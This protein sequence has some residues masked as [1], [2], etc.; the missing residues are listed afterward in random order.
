MPSRKSTK[1]SKKPVP[2]RPLYGVAI[3]DAMKRGD[4]KE[5]SALAKEGRKQVASV[6][7]ALATLEKKIG[8]S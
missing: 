1:T 6:K 7:S 8:A 3:Y 4:A 2:I 5:M